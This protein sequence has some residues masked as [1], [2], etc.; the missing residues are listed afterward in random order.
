MP[1]RQRVLRAVC[2]GYAAVFLGILVLA[3]A[4][5]LGGLVKAPHAIPAA[6][7]LGHVVL[8]FLLGVSA[9]V[10]L[11]SPALGVRGAA[12]E[13]SPPTRRWKRSSP[14][15]WSSMFSTKGTVSNCQFTSAALGRARR[16]TAAGGEG[17]ARGRTRAKP[18]TTGGGKGRT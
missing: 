9:Y 17:E 3:D 8:Y 5:L 6:D 18:G 12:I 1:A 7:K 4:G 14:A 13:A 16:A 11:P 10:L 15:K 2:L